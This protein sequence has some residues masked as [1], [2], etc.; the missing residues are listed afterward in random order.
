LTR[1]AGLIFVMSQAKL[2]FLLV[3][4]NKLKD[5][6]GGSHEVP[7]KPNNLDPILLGPP[8]QPNLA[9]AYSRQLNHIGEM[10]LQQ[11]HRIP[12]RLLVSLQWHGVGT[13]TSVWLLNDHPSSA[14]E[15]ITNWVD[16]LIVA[17]VLMSRALIVEQLVNLALLRT[18]TLG[19]G[20]YRVLG[21]IHCPTSSSAKA[22]L[23]PMNEPPYLD[24]LP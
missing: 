22:K 7:A 23:E 9:Q 16:L 11:N 20:P 17:Q 21:A 15:N 2:S 1:L 18:P 24:V 14:R 10:E 12:L 3:N 5:L 8:K 19:K 13:S 6:A 4:I